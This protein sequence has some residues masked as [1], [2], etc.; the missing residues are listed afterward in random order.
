MEFLTQAIFTKCKSI[1]TR[2]HLGSRLTDFVSIFRNRRGYMIL[3]DD[4]KQSLN[5]DEKKLYPGQVYEYEY[6]PINGHQGF[7]FFKT[8]LQA[9]TERLTWLNHK[10][11]FRIVEVEALGEIDEYVYNAQKYFYG[12][13]AEGS[14]EKP[15]NGRIAT[16][17]IRVIRELE[18]AEVQDLLVP[19]YMS[20]EEHKKWVSGIYEYDL[21]HLR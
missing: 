15:A 1:S 19:I 7:Q 17:K 20:N 14:E 5:S 8:V 21:L 11:L 12:Y 4:W 3:T 9:Y 2:L 16:N 18:F 13:G 10:A 6:C